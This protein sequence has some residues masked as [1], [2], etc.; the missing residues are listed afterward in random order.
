MELQTNNTLDFR[1]TKE[2]MIDMLIDEKLTAIKKEISL[3]E[4]NKQVNN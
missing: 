3:G 1:L 4:T 2:D